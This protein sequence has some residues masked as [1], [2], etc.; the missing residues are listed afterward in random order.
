M[1][2]RLLLQ[3]TAAATLAL[4]PLGQGNAAQHEVVIGVLY[5]MT[6]PVAQVGI[7]AVAAVK[8]AVEIV[9][10]DV[11]LNVPMGPGKG[12]TNLGGAKVRIV[13]IDHGGKPDVGQAE[14]ERLIT[15]E[16]VDAL[17]GA[18]YSSTSGAAALS[19]CTSAVSEVVVFL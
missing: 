10:E 15:Q 9:N 18:Y 7:D 4:A 14:A 5:P 19:R 11:D 1:K 12:L 13:V 2:R 6:G 16:K 17:F 3:L 8:T